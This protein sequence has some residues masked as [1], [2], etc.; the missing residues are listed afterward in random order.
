MVRLL[1]WGDGAVSP[2]VSAAPG[3]VPQLEALDGRVV[4]SHTGKVKIDFA[5]ANP[6]VPAHVSTLPPP[7]A[8]LAAAPAPPDGTTGLVHF[9]GSGE[10]GFEHVWVGGAGRDFAAADKFHEY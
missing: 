1:G 9:P 5:I 6:D 4:P 8:D 10:A 7:A 3:F 2:R